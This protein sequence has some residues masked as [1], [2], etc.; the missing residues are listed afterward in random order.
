MGSDHNAR[1]GPATATTAAG[2]AAG[3]SAGAG[4]G[5]GAC[6]SPAAGDTDLLPLLIL[7]PLIL[8]L[9]LLLLPLLLRLQPLDYY[10]CCRHPTRVHRALPAHQRHGCPRRPRRKP[11]ERNFAPRGSARHGRPSSC[12]EERATSPSGRACAGAQLGG[13]SAHA[14]WRPVRLGP[15]LRS[16][17]QGRYRRRHYCRCRCRFFASADATAVDTTAEAAPD[18][19]EITAAGTSAAASAA[20]APNASI[21]RCPLIKSAVIRD[22]RGASDEHAM[23]RPGGQLAAGVARLG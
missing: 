10:C 11:R 7:R 22:S 23:V 5:A 14:G 21:E 16:Q 15:E 13:V 17:R 9:R 18:A 1:V 19:A 4:A 8:L 20:I 6:A 3:T 12:P 2:L